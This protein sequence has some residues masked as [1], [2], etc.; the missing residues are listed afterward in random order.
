MEQEWAAYSF[1]FP[2]VIVFQLLNTSVYYKVNL[3][4]HDDLA[5]AIKGCEILF[6]STVQLKLCIMSLRKIIRFIST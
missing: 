3:S 1:D 2:L 4:R 6:H 5:R